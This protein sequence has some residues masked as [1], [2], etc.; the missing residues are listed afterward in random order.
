M[1]A[2]GQSAPL[3]RERLL[4]SPGVARTILLLLVTACIV[5][6]LLVDDTAASSQAITAAGPD[7]TRLLR[8]MAV[9]KGG[10]AVAA[11]AAVLWRLGAVVT[12]GRL[13]AYAVSCGAMA[14]GP[15]L[16]WSMAHVV[17]G[18]VLLHGGL[19][20]AIVLV[21]RDPAVVDQLAALSAAR[22]EQRFG[23]HAKAV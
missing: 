19:A 15:M 14:A 13:A 1:I 22:R 12:P 20:T 4:L 11:S 3:T 21:W 23:R 2:I 16:I 7:L 8:M 18:A 10:I 17:A 9:L 6:G 5:W